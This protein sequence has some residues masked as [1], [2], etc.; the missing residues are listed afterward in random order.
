MTWGLVRGA[1]GE[2]RGAA[3]EAAWK[4]LDIYQQYDINQAAIKLAER[5]RARSSTCRFSPHMARELIL[6]LAL[7]DAINNDGIKDDDV[8]SAF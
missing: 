2:I 4:S 8:H 3:I 7:W 6:V 5:M 1:G